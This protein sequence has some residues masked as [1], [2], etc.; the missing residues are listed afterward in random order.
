MKTIICKTLIDNYSYSKPTSCSRR[1]S[2]I[3][4]WLCW[5]G[6]FL[7]TPLMYAQH[8]PARPTLKDSASH[9]M[10]LIPDVQSY[11]KFDAN[12]PLLD[13]QTA[14]IAN[15]RQSL[16]VF[17]ALCTGDLVEQNNRLLPHPEN[18]NQ[19]SKEQWEAVSNDSFLLDR[20]CRTL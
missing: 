10:V 14:W 12:Q 13:L 7:L 5:I 17:T 6:F 11:V 3:Q 9:T 1:H 8:Y 15:N 18:G 2:Y 16:R 20:S 19:T 4:R